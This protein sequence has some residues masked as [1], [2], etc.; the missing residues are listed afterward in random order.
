MRAK[1]A[2]LNA[3]HQSHSTTR[4]AGL[5]RMKRPPEWCAKYVGIPF[6][7]KGRGPDG[8]DCW[9]IVRHVLAEEFG[10]TGL[11]DYV[12]AYTRPGDK[13]S[14]ATAVRAGLAEGWQK[15]DTVDAGTLII[16]R[17]AGRPWHCALAV[18]KEWMLHTLEGVNACL[19]RMD[20][21]V[22][23][24]RIEGFYQYGK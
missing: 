1:G 15:V 21:M 11:P 7:E 24:G 3:S 23:N 20:S 2:I 17:L 8:F 14:V 19:E 12:D 6:K 10:I 5:V 16:L 4:N 13:Q 22:W 18:N 9:G